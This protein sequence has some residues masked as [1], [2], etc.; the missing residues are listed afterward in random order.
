[1]WSATFY[2]H[3]PNYGEEY[4]LVGIYNA[5]AKAWKALARKAPKCLADGTV[6]VN[7]IEI[8]KDLEGEDDF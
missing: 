5:Q 6:E 1:M 7:E 3:V 4:G 2:K 8:N